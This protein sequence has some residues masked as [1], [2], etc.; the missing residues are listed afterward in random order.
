MET[1]SLSLSLSVCVCVCVEGR[2]FS[3]HVDVVDVQKDKL[4]VLVGVLT[5]ISA[6][7]GLHSRMH[8]NRFSHKQ[9]EVI[10]TLWFSLGILLTH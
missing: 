6:T 1:S 2:P 10:M 8:S 3:H 5:L 9:D 4:C 7:F